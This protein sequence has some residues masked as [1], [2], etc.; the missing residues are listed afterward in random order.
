MGES[1]LSPEVEREIAE[2]EDEELEELKRNY[3]KCY[4]VHEEEPEKGAEREGVDGE[5]N[6]GEGKGVSE[7]GEGDE[8]MVDKKVLMKR[9]GFV[10]YTEGE[11]FERLVLAY[12]TSCCDKGRPLHS[13]AVNV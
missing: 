5:G 13:I 3:A 10:N 1:S 8:A 12:R 11:F 2:G 7:D 9:Q 4:P 6:E